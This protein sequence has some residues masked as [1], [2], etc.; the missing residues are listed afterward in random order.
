MPEDVT[1][2]QLYK[3][4]GPSSFVFNFDSQT[5]ALFGSEGWEV[6][7]NT[8]PYIVNRQYIDLQGW[9]AQQLTTFTQGVDFQH[10]RRPR[11]TTTGILEVTVVDLLTTRRLTDVELSNWGVIL[12]PAAS[13]DLPGF[14]DSTVDLME[15]IYGER[16][17]FVSN[18]TMAPGLAGSVY[19][20]IGSESFGSGNPTAM[21]RLHWTRIIFANGSGP[22]ESLTIG[23]T[24]L[25]VQAVSAKEDDLIWIERLRRSYVHHDRAGI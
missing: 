7:W 23:G 14:A 15:V 21:N 9:S 12:S 17:T 20:T 3:Q 18:S 6:L 10:S 13:D 11:S 1:P 16:T 8:L 4:I 22:T 24:N 25:V 19:V 5:D 2:H